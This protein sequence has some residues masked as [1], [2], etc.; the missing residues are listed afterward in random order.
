MR[1][2]CQL[3][4]AAGVQQVI[5]DEDGLYDPG[6]L[7]T[8]CCWGYP[9]PAARRDLVQGPGKLSRTALPREEWI[10][11]I[12][13]AH[14]GYLTLD[15]YDANRARLAQNAACTAVTGPPGR[16]AKDPHCC[17]ATSSAGPAGS[18]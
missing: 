1:L 13:G 16:P 18:A 9:R 2:D 6:N 17:R 11:F 4:S 14:P 3:R 8:A 10:S 5:C 15:Q 7:T 12:P